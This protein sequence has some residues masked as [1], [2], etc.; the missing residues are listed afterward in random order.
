MCLIVKS[1]KMIAETD[2]VVYKCLEHSPKIRTPF[3]RFPIKFVNGKTYLVMNNKEYGLKISYEVP[4]GLIFE[5][6]HAYYNKEEADL[7]SIKFQLS[8][9][10]THYGIIPKGCE[11]YLGCKNQIVSTEMIIF[12]TDK[13][14]LKYEESHEVKSVK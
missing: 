7:M 10:R 5:G 9:M 4:C 13:D 2:L 12:E 14:Y 8:K 1:P 6:V 11:Y 3:Q